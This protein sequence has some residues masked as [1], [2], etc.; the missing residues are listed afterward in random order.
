VAAVAAFGGQHVLVVTSGGPP[1][2]RFQDLTEA[3]WQTAINRTLHSALRLMRAALPHL[4]ASDRGAILVILSS[5]VREPIAN[6]TTSNL[7]RPGLDGL[8]KSMAAEIAPVRINGIAPGKVATERIAALDA[9]RAVTNGTTVEEIQR[10]Q[11]ARIPMGRYGDPAEIGR[12]AAFLLSP[13]A[14]Y[15][16]AQVVGVDGGMVRSL[17]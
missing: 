6:L 13:A 17:P 1:M 14:S 16:T 10:Q 15:V 7:I 3:D 2:R 12:V 5:S 8:I 4:R 11:I 9:G